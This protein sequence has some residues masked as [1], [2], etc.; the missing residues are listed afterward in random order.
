MLK[1]EFEQRTSFY[2][3]QALYSIIEKHYMEFNGDKD[4]FCKAYKKNADGF[5]EKIQREA[6]MQAFKALAAVENA[7]K[8]Y[9]FR[10]AELEKALECE[11]EWRP[12]E[13]TDNVRQADYKRL[14]DQ[15][16]TEHM[17]DEKAKDL[18]Y[19]WYG[20]ASEKI[21]IH[22]SIPVY[23]VNR[24]G[25]LR[26]V[27]EMDRSPLYNA[28]DWNYIRFDCGRMSYELYNDNLRPYLH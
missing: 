20:F 11:Q 23:E 16:D 14:A 6:D 26:K 22:H 24:H 2:P 9:G 19:E 10:I 5:A 15:S 3:D 4:A 8:D 25:R 18:L 12:Y 27:G 7:V 28:T 13:D 17:S 1:E 21:T